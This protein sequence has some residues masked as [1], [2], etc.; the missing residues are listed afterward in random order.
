MSRGKI[1]ADL[2]KYFNIKELVCKEVYAKFGD[3]AWH[4]LDTSLLATILTLRTQILKCS[5]VCNN[6][7]SGGQLSQRGLRCNMCQIVKGKTAP[8]LS[9]HI[10]GKGVDLSS[11]QMTAKQMRE[12]IDKNQ[13]LL[14]YN[15]RIESDVNWL[16][17]DT[18]NNTDKKIVY[19]K[20]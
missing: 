5:L 16:H 9:A 3:S 11:G 12:L 7:A 14:P 20:G 8:Y 15:V 4:F 18:L 2:Q 10:L 13:A 6:W 1:I 19:F 17:I